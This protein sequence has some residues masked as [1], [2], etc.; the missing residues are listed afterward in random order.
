MMSDPVRILERLTLVT[1]L[2]VQ[3]WDEVSGS[4][5]ADGLSVTT[6]PASNPARRVPGFPNRSGTYVMQNLPGLRDFENGAG[7]AEFWDNLDPLSRLPFVIEVVDYTRR[8]QPFLF[9]ADLPVRGLFTLECVSGSPPD[10][11]RPVV[12]LY[13]APSRAVPGGMAVLRS[14]LWNPLVDAPAAWAML[15]GRING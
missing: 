4:I 15:E 6:Y 8:F 2:G 11:A 1:P 7:D 13:S 10:K 5:I 3:F 12:P 14:S 9:S